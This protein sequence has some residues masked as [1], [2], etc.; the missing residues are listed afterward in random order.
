MHSKIIFATDLDNT[1]IHSYK[2]AKSGDICVETHE[3]KELSFMSEKA[4]NLLKEVSEICS[5]IPVTTRSFEQYRRL[6]LGISFDYAVVAHGALL[7]KKGEI[8][9]QWESENR[10]KFSTRLPHINEDGN[11]YDVRYI[12]D[13][14]IFAKA[15]DTIQ[16]VSSLQ[17]T[18]DNRIFNVFAVCNKVYIFPNGFDKG[19]S[20]EHLKQHLNIDKV[21]CAGDSELDIPMLEAADIAFAPT[22]LNLNKICIRIDETEDFAAVLLNYIRNLVLEKSFDKL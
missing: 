22:G 20:L 3:G 8:N 16:A 5:I 14:F 17:R 19:A 7:L 15:S 13:A 11:I 4:Y 21:I 12:E 10:K 9:K 1:L 6:D 2:K 18:L